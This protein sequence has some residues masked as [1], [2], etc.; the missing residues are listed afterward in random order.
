M[1]QRKETVSP[2]TMTS[3]YLHVTET[4]ETSHA[5]PPRAVFSAKSTAAARLSDEVKLDRM[6]S[7]ETNT[8]ATSSELGATS[9]EA[10]DH[11]YVN[12]AERKTSR[13]QHGS[14]DDLSHYQRMS[15]DSARSTT[16]SYVN[17]GANAGVYSYART[18]DLSLR[19]SDGTS[20]PS[21]QNGSVRKLAK[22]S[23]S[24]TLL[25]ADRPGSLSAQSRAVASGRDDYVPASPPS[26]AISIKSGSELGASSTVSDPF[27]SPTGS[28]TAS[29]VAI[30]NASP[31]VA[32]GSAS[33][34]I[35][36]PVAG[37]S[38]SKRSR[39]FTRQK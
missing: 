38:M 31:A 19:L 21:V 24:P 32:V 37:I 33:P 10:A 2:D 3:Q 11:P 22:T 27:S 15:G 7:V 4:E 8:S 6:Y 23:S 12:D 14:A 28:D 25:D 30:G 5:E 39:V 20:S 34:A 13:P 9:S 18:F 35:L 29:P 26:A 36:S 1:P 16:H 17:N